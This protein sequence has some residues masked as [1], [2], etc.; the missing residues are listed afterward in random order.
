MKNNSFSGSSLYV[1]LYH[2]CHILAEIIDQHTRRRYLAGYWFK[3]FMCFYQASILGQQLG[4]NF[5][6]FNT[7]IVKRSFF[8]I[9]SRIIDFTIIKFR[10]PEISIFSHL[11]GF[12][13]AYDFL[14]TILI[15]YVDFSKKCLAF[16]IDPV[17]SFVGIGACCPASAHNCHKLILFP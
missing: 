11:P 10:L 13:C 9:H 8:Q 3:L 12:I 4:P 7:G 5:H 16:C 2:T 6:L 17:H 1:C 15:E 14:C